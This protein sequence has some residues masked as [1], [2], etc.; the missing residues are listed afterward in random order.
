MTLEA[1][2]GSRV[3]LFD[4]LYGATTF[5]TANGEASRVS[6]AADDSCLPFERRLHSLEKLG[7]LI[8]VDDIYIAVSGADDHEIILCR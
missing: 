6:E 5:N 2:V 1:E 8:K 7:G 4:M 3:L